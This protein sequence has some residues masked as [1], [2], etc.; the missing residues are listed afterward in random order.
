MAQYRTTPT[1]APVETKVKAAAV[2]TYLGLL[3]LLAVLNGVTD[4]DLIA[5]LPDVVEVFVAP[6]LPTA[7][8]FVTSYLARHTPRPDLGR[9]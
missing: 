3:A 2:A 8:T 1:S 7:V 5:G 4:A 9:P 6:L